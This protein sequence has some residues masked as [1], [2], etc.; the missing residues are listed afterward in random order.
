MHSTR[1]MSRRRQRIARPRNWAGTSVAESTWFSP[2]ARARSDRAAASSVL[3]PIGRATS[4]LIVVVSSSHPSVTGQA[5]MITRKIGPGQGQLVLINP[6][7]RGR[8]SPA[9]ATGP[10]RPRSAACQTGTSPIA[11]PGTHRRGRG[12]D[13]GDGI[14]PRRPG[15][16]GQH[17][18]GR[19]IPAP[20]GEHRTD[21]L[22][23][24]GEAPQPAPH[25]LRRPAQQRGDQPVPGPGRLRGQ[26]RPDHRGGVRPAD[27]QHHRQQHM[28][29]P[30]AGAPRPTRNDPQPAVGVTDPPAPRMAP[31]GQHPRASRT[32][33]PTRPERPSCPT[34]SSPKAVNNRAEASAGCYVR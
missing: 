19:Q 11:E 33:Q 17:R 1:T 23:P 27:Q 25:R 2:I 12:Q 3:A 30:A 16:P 29:G 7:R 28:R 13:R 8:A 15:R 32:R 31:P 10:R 22:D 6:G 20:P 21:R 18:I 9:A 4:S 5:A 34:L 26:P 14:R 24:A